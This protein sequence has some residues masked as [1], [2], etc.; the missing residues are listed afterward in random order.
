[1]KVEDDDDW[2]AEVEPAKEVVASKSKKKKGSKKESTI[3]KRVDEVG[4]TVR[5]S[6]SANQKIRD[7]IFR[8]LP[9]SLRPSEQCFLLL[10]SIS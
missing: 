2:L 9:G 8:A 1:M 7:R 3:E 5:Y 6:A 4:N 10:Y